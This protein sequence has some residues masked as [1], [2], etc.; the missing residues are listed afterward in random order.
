QRFVL[1]QSHILKTSPRCLWQLAANQ[2]GESLV[3]RS[4]EDLESRGR[5]VRR[6]WLRW[7]N[8]PRKADTCFLTLTGHHGP[9]DKLAM[10]CDGRRLVSSSKDGTLRVWDVQSGDELLVLGKLKIWDYET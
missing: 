2:P 7:I 10:S 5:V 4:A 3:C 9:V 6:A 8:K 1:S